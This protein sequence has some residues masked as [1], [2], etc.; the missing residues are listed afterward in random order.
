MIMFPTSGG[1]VEPLIS[2][3]D[4]GFGNLI[5]VT[6]WQFHR[7]FGFIYDLEFDDC[8]TPNFWSQK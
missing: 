5:R 4:D 2:F 6:D 7:A 8:C 1:T 3:A